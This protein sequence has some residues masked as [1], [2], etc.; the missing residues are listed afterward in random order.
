MSDGD[1]WEEVNDKRY[2]ALKGQLKIY[3]VHEASWTIWLYKD[4][5]VQGILHSGEDSKWNKTFE[6]FINKKRK[7]AVD[8]WGT[9]R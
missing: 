9:D 4:M 7:H 6:E 3:D 8:F 5:G 1:Q 2:E